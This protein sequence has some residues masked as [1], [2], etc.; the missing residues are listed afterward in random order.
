MTV[1]SQ[2]L[3]HAADEVIF[4]G[5]ADLAIEG[6]DYYATAAKVQDLYCCDELLIQMNQW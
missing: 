6:V 1:E 3:I 2:D 4:Q 5:I